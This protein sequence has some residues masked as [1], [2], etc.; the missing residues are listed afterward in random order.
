MS[1]IDRKS[2]MRFETGLSVHSI[3][4]A[5]ELSSRAQQWPLGACFPA[6]RI[7]PKRSLSRVCSFRRVTT[8][9]GKSPEKKGKR[10]RGRA[11][12]IYPPMKMMERR[13]R[14]RR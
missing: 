2:Q 1:F 8:A 5:T 14:H 6:L 12:G 7:P 11:R 4:I 9:I 10:E 3:P 13:L